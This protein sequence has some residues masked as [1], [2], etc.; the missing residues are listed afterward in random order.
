[1]MFPFLKGNNAIYDLLLF[2]HTIYTPFSSFI[3]IFSRCKDTNLFLFIKTIFSGQ[4]SVRFSQC[5][6]AASK[7]LRIWRC[8][9]YLVIDDMGVFIFQVCFPNHQLRATPISVLQSSYW[10]D[11][12]LY[13]GYASLPEGHNFASETCKIG[14]SC[15]CASGTFTNGKSGY[16]SANCLIYF[17]LRIIVSYGSQWPIHQLIQICRALY[18]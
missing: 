4:P 6:R 17:R 18:V 2:T 1:M 3:S 14:F 16:S 13:Q 5:W 12:L 15:N 9:S 8:N 10:F 7:L 11:I